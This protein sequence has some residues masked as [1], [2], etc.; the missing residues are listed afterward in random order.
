MVDYFGLAAADVALLAPW[1]PLFASPTTPV[2]EGQY[3][4]EDGDVAHFPD[5]MQ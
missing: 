5:R 3:P 1:L 4:A 2:A